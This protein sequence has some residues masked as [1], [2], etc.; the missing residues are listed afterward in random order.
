[1]IGDNPKGDIRGANSMGMRSILV[2]SGIYNPEWDFL[3]D[4]DMPWLEVD[5]MYEAVQQIIE[6]EKLSE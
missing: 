6:K 4:E 3:E 2:R 5:N 1:M